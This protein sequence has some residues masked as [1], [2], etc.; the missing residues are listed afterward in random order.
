L[1]TC[2]AFGI[3]R[4]HPFVQG[5]KRTGFAAMVG[6]LGAN[7]YRLLI[8]D[9]LSCAEHMLLVLEGAAPEDSFADQ[10]RRVIEAVRSWPEG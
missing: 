6:F 4:N 1:A 5:N 2:L 7:G 8:G 10:L 3:A 9:D